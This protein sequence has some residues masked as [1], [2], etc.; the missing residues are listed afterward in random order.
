MVSK[1]LGRLAISTF[2]VLG[3]ASCTHQANTSHK[4]DVLV[5]YDAFNQ[6]DPALVDKILSAS[7]DDVPPAPGQAPGRQGAKDI[8]V[9]LTTAFPDL[10]LTIKDV[11]QDGNKVIVRSEITGTQTGPFL[12]VPPRNR[13]IS[14][15][16]IDIH[17]FEDGKIVRSWHTEDWMTGLRQLKSES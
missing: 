15:Q 16:A 2:V 14:I 3:A 4:N 10:K 5:W 1:V 12:G 7:W 11:L 17:Q 6:K 13:K 8:L 9:E